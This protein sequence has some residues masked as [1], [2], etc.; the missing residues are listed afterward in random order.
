MAAGLGSSGA[1]E[2]Q[3]PLGGRPDLD[4]WHE[5]LA[6]NMATDYT[7]ITWRGT[8]WPVASRLIVPDQRR[9]SRCVELSGPLR[10]RRIGPL[11]ILLGISFGGC[12]V[13]PARNQTR[14]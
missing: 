3:Q 14:W 13:C 2:A 9:A 12:T 1:P 4:S 7:L 5:T 11:G 8:V 10:F 6:I